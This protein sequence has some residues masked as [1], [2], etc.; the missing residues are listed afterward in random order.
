MTERD[1]RRIAELLRDHDAL[2]E[3]FDDTI[4][5]DLRHEKYPLIAFEIGTRNRSGSGT[6]WDG[7]MLLTRAT[8]TTM[9]TAAKRAVLEELRDLGV[10]MEDRLR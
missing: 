1:A 8:V 9:F 7:E 3:W 6:G 4:A 5:K 10:N 2:V